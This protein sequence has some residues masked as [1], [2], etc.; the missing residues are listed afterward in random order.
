M[1]WGNRAAGETWETSVPSDGNEMKQNM[2]WREREQKKTEEKRSGNDE[3]RNIYIVNTKKMEGT[4]R[5]RAMETS[6]NADRPI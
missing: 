3:Y 4:M 2:W 5:E 6:R 1:R